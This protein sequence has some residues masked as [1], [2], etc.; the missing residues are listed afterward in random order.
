[1]LDAESQEEQGASV[2]VPPPLVFL[3]MTLLGAALHLY[4]KPLP[5]PLGDIVRWLVAGICGLAGIGL[6]GGAIGLFKRTKQ[7]PEPWKPSPE[8]IDT[9]VYGYTRNPMYVAMTALQI[10]IGVALGYAWVVILAPVS[11][12]VVYVTAVRHEEAYLEQK[13][14][15]PYVAYKGSVRRWL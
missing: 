6:M 15:E 1:M 11:L 5:L 7:E 12:T 10:A 9:G 13:F 2:R 3:G 8:I 14:G 4:L